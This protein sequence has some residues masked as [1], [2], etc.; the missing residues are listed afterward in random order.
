MAMGAIG[1]AVNV[2]DLRSLFFVSNSNGPNNVAFNWRIFTDSFIWMK[3]PKSD[4]I[5]LISVYSYFDLLLLSPEYKDFYITDISLNVISWKDDIYCCHVQWKK[6]SQCFAART[7]N[8]VIKV[9]CNCHW[10]LHKK[11]KRRWRKRK[12]YCSY[13]HSTTFDGAAEISTCLFTAKLSGFGV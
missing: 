7:V 2:C 11:F 1:L 13:L 8:N 3:C 4:P 6:G 12:R 10:S 9:C 5:L